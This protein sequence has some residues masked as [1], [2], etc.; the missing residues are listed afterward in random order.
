M[1][2][3]QQSGIFIHRLTVIFRMGPVGGTDFAQ[4]TSGLAH[5]V[6]NTKRAANF[7]QLTARNDH[8]FAVGRGGQHQ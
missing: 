3:H 7:H 4:N 2:F 5:H 6:R 8:L 1:D